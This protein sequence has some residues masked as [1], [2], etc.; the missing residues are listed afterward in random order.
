MVIVS[1]LVLWL[2]PLRMHADRPLHQRLPAI[3]RSKAGGSERLHT[4]HSDLSFDRF[5]GGKLPEVEGR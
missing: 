3:H 5:P 2:A 4:A 1:D